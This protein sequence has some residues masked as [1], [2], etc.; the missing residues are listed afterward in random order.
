[1]ICKVLRRN[2]L[3]QVFW[4]VQALALCPHFLHLSVLHAFGLAQVFF[5]HRLHSAQP[6]PKVIR[7]TAKIITLKKVTTFFMETP[8]SKK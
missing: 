7:P 1:M 3:G 2:Y 6:A 5:P 4:Q 8:L